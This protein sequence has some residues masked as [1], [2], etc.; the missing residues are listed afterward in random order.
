MDIVSLIVGLVSIGLAIYSIWFAN[1]ESKQSSE[2][3][4]KT[5]ELLT[6]VEHKADLIDRTVQMEQ[7]LT[8]DVVN[9]LLDMIGQPK[10]DF[11]PMTMEDVDA[12][13]AKADSEIDKRIESV[14][15]KI[16]T[17]RVENETL[18]IETGESKK[19]KGSPP[20]S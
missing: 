2:N 20:S 9:K 3:Y 16:P 12:A 8:F 14:V 15:E 19:N 18:I 5:K 4:T 6:A 17:F 13:I 11:Q 7:K 1:K 10:V